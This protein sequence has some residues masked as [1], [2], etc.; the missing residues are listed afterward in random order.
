MEAL[1]RERRLSVAID[2]PSSFKKG[3]F[4]LVIWDG[5]D[6]SFREEQ[7]FSDLAL[8]A[9]PF[10]WDFFRT[11]T[12]VQG[13][14]LTVTAHE[15]SCDGAIVDT[16]EIE[17][18]AGPSDG[19]RVGLDIP[20][21]DAD[22]F[23]PVAHGGTDCDDTPGVGAA[24][25][26]G[27]E[28]L[29]D[30]LDNDCDGTRNE[31]FPTA[32]RDL[33]GDGDGD[34]AHAECVTNPLPS[35][36]YVANSRDCDDVDPDVR[37]HGLEVCDAIDNN[38]DGFVDEGCQGSLKEVTHHHLKDT[39]GELK[40]RTVSQGPSGYPVWIA[41]RG[42]ALVVRK[43]ATSKF[44]SFSYN[45]SPTPPQDGS[46]PASANH[47]GNH[48]W[49]S[50]WVD[51]RG[52]VF[53]G[54][55]AGAVAVHDGATCLFS[56]ALPEGDDV[57]GVSGQKR[58]DIIEVHLV[59]SSGRLFSWE[60][61]TPASPKLPY[62]D[63]P[64]GS[65]PTSSYAGIH[66]FGE[67]QLLLAASSLEV[68]SLQRIVGFLQDHDT[69][70]IFSLSPDARQGRVTAIWASSLASA[71]AVGEQGTVW[72]GS[73]TSTWTLLPPTPEVATLNFSSVAGLPTGQAYVVDSGAKGALRRLTR[74]G[75]AAQPR[76]P[77]TDRPLHDVSVSSERDFWVVGDDRVFHY[78]EP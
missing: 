54:G 1:E 32:Y 64:Q 67:S 8:R 52:Y 22:G 55:E 20:D 16:Q 73:D 42:G 13:G 34:A 53:L 69:P 25:Y 72:R 66:V 45:P 29:C 31:G 51:P 68:P 14:R 74:L 23:V 27:H 11:G 39:R 56:E 43:S 47:C 6:R 9:P 4:R 7:T 48:H 63:H 17:F 2:Y 57:T 44:E 76:L 61:F 35:T 5:N 49:L 18:G 37:P 33:D 70:R 26:P 30:S 40:W 28:E 41:G 24:A 21:A 10:T 62:V 19:L 3:C 75:W 60:K 15:Q 58:N 77:V 38:C 36:G 65:S 46:P 71:F 12:L 59:T 50:S 78:P